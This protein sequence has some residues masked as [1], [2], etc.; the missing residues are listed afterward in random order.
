MKVLGIKVVPKERPKA[1]TRK[2]REQRRAYW[3]Q[4][5]GEHR[6]KQHS[7][8]KRRTHEHDRVYRREKRRG[9]DDR[10][11]SVGDSSSAKKIYQIRVRFSNDPRKFAKSVDIP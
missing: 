1:L 4:K 11:G 8:K 2:A 3:A 10:E 9:T 5:Q 7:Q 6:A